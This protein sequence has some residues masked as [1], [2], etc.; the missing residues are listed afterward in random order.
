M[1]NKEIEDIMMQEVCDTFNLNVYLFT[2]YKSFDK[3][4]ILLF[5]KN[6]ETKAYQYYVKVMNEADFTNM[7]TG[8]NHKAKEF[9]EELKKVIEMENEIDFKRRQNALLTYRELEKKPDFNK[10]DEAPA[11]AEQI[12]NSMYKKDVSPYPYIIDVHYHQ[13]SREFRVVDEERLFTRL[14]V[15]SK[16]P[17]IE[18]MD[19]Y[20][21][22]LS[23]LLQQEEKQISEENIDYF[24]REFGISPVL[25]DEDKK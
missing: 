6:S 24:V 1:D 23:F 3:N 12:V 11:Y 18:D 10:E 25:P 16:L 19:Y 14:E 13:K 7:N 4:T 21:G 15:D 22:K 9:S 2:Y 5:D 20:S 8:I 17:I